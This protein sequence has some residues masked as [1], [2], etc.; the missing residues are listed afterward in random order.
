MTLP[1]PEVIILNKTIYEI[2]HR[3]MQTVGVCTGSTATA[4]PD[5]YFNGNED[6]SEECVCVKR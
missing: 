4:F 5:S 3:L 1:L 2:E 6:E